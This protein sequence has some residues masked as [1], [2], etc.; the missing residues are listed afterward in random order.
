MTKFDCSLIL[1]SIHKTQY[2][3]KLHYIRT[4]H[5]CFRLF[6]FPSIIID[7][8]YLQSVLRLTFYVESKVDVK[9]F[10]TSLLLVESFLSANLVL[11]KEYRVEP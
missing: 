5:R 9:Y 7:P 6:G 4:N 10:Q 11:Q 8:T 1:V 3:V 2:T